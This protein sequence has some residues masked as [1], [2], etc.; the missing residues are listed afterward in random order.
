MLPIS[1]LHNN[2]LWQRRQPPELT[3][4]PE[5]GGLE[6]LEITL[7]CSPHLQWLPKQLSYLHQMAGKG[8]Q[9]SLS[10]HMLLWK[11]RG[12]FSCV[13][14]GCEYCHQGTPWKGTLVHCVRLWQHPCLWVNPAPKP[15]QAGRTGSNFCIPPPGLAVSLPILCCCLS[16]LWDATTCWGMSELEDEVGSLHLYKR[17]QTQWAPLGKVTH[18]EICCRQWKQNRT[19]QHI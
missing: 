13:C 6:A 14:A 5:P 7:T 2:S 11:C 16:W 10:Q 1:N 18:K 4:F 15:A 12:Q 3:P 9:N 19:K 8:F 17:K